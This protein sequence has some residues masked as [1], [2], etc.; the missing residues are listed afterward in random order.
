MGFVPRGA[1]VRYANVNTGLGG[2]RIPHFI[3]HAQAG[4]TRYL[5]GTDQP[6]GTVVLNRGFERGLSNACENV[7]SF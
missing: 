4:V 2:R 6:P 7:G 1:D 3:V 5:L